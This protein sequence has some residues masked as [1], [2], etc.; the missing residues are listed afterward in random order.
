MAADVDTWTM[1][2]EE[3][4]IDENNYQ[5]FVIA[6]EMWEM[7]LYSQCTGTTD[8][9]TDEHVIYAAAMSIMA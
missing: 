4:N 8:K 1:A 2:R 9:L 6:K 5:E 3:D 7:E